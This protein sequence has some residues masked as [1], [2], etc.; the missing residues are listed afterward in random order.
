M[1]EDFAHAFRI[2]LGIRLPCPR[3]HPRAV[4]RIPTGVNPPIISGA[5]C[6]TYSSIDFISTCAVLNIPGNAS[7]MHVAV[8][9]FWQFALLPRHVV[10][11]ASIAARCSVPESNRRRAKIASR[12]RASELLRR[13]QFEIASIPAPARTR[14]ICAAVSANV[15]AHCPGSRW[16]TRRPFAAPIDV[17]NKARRRTSRV[18][19]KAPAPNSHSPQAWFAAAGNL[20]SKPGCPANWRNKNSPCG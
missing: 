8:N 6:F 19:R 7:S 14:R 5:P 15:A 4:G 16:P 12:S 1:I 18:R 10:G 20:P 11:P 13:M 9:G 2:T 17:E 3:I